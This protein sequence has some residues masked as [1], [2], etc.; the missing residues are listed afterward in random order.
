MIVVDEFADLADQLAGSRSA[1][2]EFY[3]HIRRV[4]QLGRNRGV[5]L[6]LCTQRPSA[7]LVPT[8][9]RNL[10]NARVAL[11][12]NDSTASRMILDEP[13]AEQLQ[14]HGDL[15]VKDDMTMV[16]AQAFFAEV[17]F[18]ESIVSSLASAS[19]NSQIG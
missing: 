3:R 5:H 9:I 2:D 10:M 13:G 18:I 12:V 17:S 14:L 11:R 1:K 19:Q 7:E 6:I 8:H 4:A 15:L 16:R